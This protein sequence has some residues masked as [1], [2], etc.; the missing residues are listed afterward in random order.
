[1]V[2]HG[3]D[4]L[5]GA[6]AATEGLR[7]RHQLRKFGDSP[8]ML[9][10]EYRP[11]HTLWQRILDPIQ[12]LRTPRPWPSIAEHWA[13]SRKGDKTVLFLG[14]GASS[15]EG[16][17]TQSELLDC[18]AQ[19]CPHSRQAGR[20]PKDWG[21]VEAFL[22]ELAP[23]ISIRDRSLED[24]LTFLDKAES[25]QEVVAGVGPK[26]LREPRR[27][28][29]NCIA[30][31][32]DAAQ[33]GTL[34]AVSGDGAAASGAETPMRQLGRFLTN[35]AVAGDRDLWS[36]VSTNWD[37]TLDHALG[38]GTVAPVVD[39]CTYTI[40]WE[41]Y[42]GH[43]QGAGDQPVPDV[44]SVW[45]RPLKLPTIKLLKLHG[46]LNWLWCPTCSRLF[47]SPVRNIALHGTVPGGFRR[48]VYCPECRP[49]D[50]SKNDTAPLLREVLVT[51]T[52]IKRLDMVHLKMIWY[53]ALV[54]ISEAGRVFFVGYSA[55]PAD[56]EVRYM[57]AKAFAS[58]NRRREVIVVTDAKNTE[59]NALGWN[60]QLLI[61]KGVAVRSYG[62]EG[63]VDEIVNGRV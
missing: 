45:K 22:E 23:R 13:K 16:L 62:V 44:P 9:R 50:R 46:S 61:G 63:L 8:F 34:A 57:L 52:M 26:D 17:P 49:T 7:I 28:L 36:V 40:P 25:A 39:Y 35:S 58:G 32:L 48:R 30:N 42:F 54:E 3:P 31:V 37:T 47:V 4:D 29:L 27:A 2:C 20:L 56:F 43:N 5:R 15:G 51:P 38:R 41:R 55:P 19:F 24:C 12:P 33:D 21:T 53:N 10:S 1:V 60:Y 14:A 59:A 18:A 11:W 6:E